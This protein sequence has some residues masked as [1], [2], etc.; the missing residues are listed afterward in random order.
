[1]APPSASAPAE[2]K[3]KRVRDL[4]SSYYGSSGADG[5][6]DGSV[7]DD[8]PARSGQGAQGRRAVKPVTPRA[9]GLDSSQFDVD[10]CVYTWNPPLGYL[11]VTFMVPDVG[12]SYVC[13][14]S[15]GMGLQFLP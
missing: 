4:L 6:S 1:M 3:A 14:T 15:R 9:A 13:L 8:S 11:V 5:G 12:Q 2:E 10:K 7:H